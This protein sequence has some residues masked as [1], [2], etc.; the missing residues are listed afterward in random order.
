MLMVVMMTQAQNLENPAVEDSVDLLSS[1]GEEDGNAAVPIEAEGPIREK[2][3][4][5]KRRGY[6]Y[7]PGY[8]GY[9]RYYRQPYYRGG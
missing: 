5:W 2:R 4:K 1:F 3:H 9:G 7:N 8:Y 6:Y